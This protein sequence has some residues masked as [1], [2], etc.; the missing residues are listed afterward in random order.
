MRRLLLLLFLRGGNHVYPRLSRVF[1]R[2]NARFKRSARLCLSLKS[3]KL[4]VLNETERERERDC[5]T[6][7][8]DTKTSAQNKKSGRFA[9]N[10]VLF[11][12]LASPVKT[13]FVE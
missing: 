5:E 7:V 6:E 9:T 4:F 11:L 8:C 12:M 3:P 10:R 13:K 2:N 1:S